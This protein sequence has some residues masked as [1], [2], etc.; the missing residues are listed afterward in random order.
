MTPR[1]LERH[2][3][4]ARPAIAP[5]WDEARASRVEAAIP[6]KA[7][8]RRRARLLVGAAA[9]AVLVG[10]GAFLV[11]P[12]QADVAIEPVAAADATELPSP[13]GRAFEVTHGA[14]KF[15][16]KPGRK[17][18]VRVV[19]GEVEVRV[20]GTRFLVERAGARVHVA[21]EEGSVQVRWKGEVAVLRAGADQWF[22]PSPPPPPIEPSPVPLPLAHEALVEQ[23]VPHV[24]EP[25]R[26]TK[27]APAAKPEPAHVF[28][29][30]PEWKRLAS[31]G[32]FARAWEA[33]KEAPPPRDETAELLLAADV[34][35]L[36]G[37][38]E[39]A[40]APL[41]QVV[42]KH[43][44]DARAPLA[45]FTLGRVLLDD[46]GRPREAAAAFETARTLS[47]D[48][49]LAEDALARQVEAA[50]RAQDAKVREL[51]EQFLQRYPESPR[52]RSV[53]H[54]GGLE[55]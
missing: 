5:A 16:V 34:A 2:L 26:P 14:V 32:E 48:S 17:Q 52:V 18:P 6:E 23:P 43:H 11:P 28:E 47:P 21:V 20:M 31:I 50:S 22:P 42:T 10:A 38:A 25:A 13:E 44:D 53:R 54:F 8:A 41:E 27:K 30:L 46:L 24:E 55:R 45:A 7:R 51:A 37:H 40:V 39:S 35:R 3:E 12:P 36:S 49:R 9:L 19:A 29:P 15:A 33:M 1:E 4:E